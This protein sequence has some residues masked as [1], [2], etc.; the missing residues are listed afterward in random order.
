MPRGNGTGPLGM[1]PR[2]G[3]GAGFCSGFRLSGYANP[4]VRNYRAFG[5]GNCRRML[6]YSSMLTGCGYLAYRLAN[7][8]GRK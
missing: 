2:T 8:R 6:W 7:R 1:G 3:R 5:R 4:N